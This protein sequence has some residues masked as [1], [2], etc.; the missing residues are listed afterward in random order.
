M[1]TLPTRIEKECVDASYTKGT[2][3]DA[4]VFVTNLSTA[5]TGVTS[6]APNTAIRIGLLEAHN[7]IS[8]IHV[9]NF[10]CDAGTGI[11]GQEY[12]RAAYLGYVYIAL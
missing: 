3:G 8:A 11:G 6:V 2:P 7:V 1:T 5:V 12:S 10:A 9:D 4:G